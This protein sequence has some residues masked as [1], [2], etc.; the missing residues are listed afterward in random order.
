MRYQ[1]ELE[2]Q[3]VKLEQ[4][5]DWPM[6]TEVNQKSEIIKNLPHKWAKIFSIK[7]RDIQMGRRNL[8]MNKS[9]HIKPLT[10]KLVRWPTQTV[11]VENHERKPIVV[12]DYKS[13]S[14]YLLKANLL[15]VGLKFTY[16]TIQ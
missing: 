6:E 16:N 14:E 8:F 10:L 15:R 3:I 13:S 7:S 12:S 4:N 5:T 1:Q 2:K 11:Q 9:L